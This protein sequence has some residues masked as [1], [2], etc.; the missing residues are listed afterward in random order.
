M[1][2]ACTAELSAAVTPGCLISNVHAHCSNESCQK[3]KQMT[4]Y[5]RINIL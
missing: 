5:R 1:V 2:I 4:T 3:L